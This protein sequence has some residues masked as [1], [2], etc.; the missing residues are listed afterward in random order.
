MAEEG[1]PL[2]QLVTDLQNKFGP[3]Y[4]G[5]RDLHIADDVKERAIRRAAE[6]SNLGKFQVLKK[7]SK[8]G[9]KFYLDA[10]QLNGGAEPW[11]LLR[12]SGTEHVALL[13]R[14]GRSGLGRRNLA[15][16]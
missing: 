3:H 1:K 11:I 15:R 13:R 16:C 6:Q 2:G 9:V 4:Y 14:G 10:P 8:D 12:A 5:R 7:E